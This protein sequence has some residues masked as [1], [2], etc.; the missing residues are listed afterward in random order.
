MIYQEKLAAEHFQ[1]IRPGIEPFCMSSTL[2]SY[3]IICA[4]KSVSTCKSV[5]GC[6]GG[7]SGELERDGRLP[8]CVVVRSAGPESGGAD[9]S[10]QGTPPKIGEHRDAEATPIERRKED[11]ETTDM[12]ARMGRM[13]R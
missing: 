5:A 1:H 6:A 3:L 13:R 10:G 4:Y 11:A 7:S 9:R 12:A 2:C 8:I